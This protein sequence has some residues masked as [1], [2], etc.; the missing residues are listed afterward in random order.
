MMTRG[1]RWRFCVTVRLVLQHFSYRVRQWN[2]HR[3]LRVQGVVAGDR[4][5]LTLATIRGRV[6]SSRSR[7]SVPSA[8]V[9]VRASGGGGGSRVSVAPPRTE[10][11]R[12]SDGPVDPR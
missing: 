5:V 2:R 4:H 1:S 12:R 8:S 7:E 9:I 6:A 11:P 3:A 10:A